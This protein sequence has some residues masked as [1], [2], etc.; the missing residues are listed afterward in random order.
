MVFARDVVVFPLI[1]TIRS[2]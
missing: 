2:S 1:V